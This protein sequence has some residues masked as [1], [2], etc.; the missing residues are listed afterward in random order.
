MEAL[1]G[2]SSKNGPFPM[3]MLNNQRVYTFR[4]LDTPS[5]Y[6][7]A[8]IYQLFGD[9]LWVLGES[10]YRYVYIYDVQRPQ[11]NPQ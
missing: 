11:K 4:F 1:M 10:N 7:N 3:A 9:V 2:K 5:I 8:V 6:K